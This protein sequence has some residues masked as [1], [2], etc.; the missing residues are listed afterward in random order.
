MRLIHK[1]KEPR[2]L[3]EYG[4]TEQAT[5]EGLPTATKVDLRAA[6]IRDQG[7][8][9][10]YCM[11]RIHHDEAREAKGLDQQSEG[12]VRIEHWKPQSEYPDLQLAWTN[13]FA[14][15]HGN[16]GK[17]PKD[18]HC[19]VRKGKQEMTVSPL[20]PKHIASLTYGTAGQIQS[21]DQ[22]LQKDLDDV[23]NLNHVTLQRNRKEAILGMLESLLQAERKRTGKPAGTLPVPVL[24]AKL[25]RCNEFDAQGRLP[26]FAGALAYKLEK[27]LGI[28]RTA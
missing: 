9:C 5:Y 7:G 24:R 4:K 14:A 19:D 1:G 13:L 3:V 27:R 6:L 15:C 11:G 10:C 28:S 17:D 18:Q 25:S 2:A 26:P 20:L 12:Q 21:N 16:E 23:L 8:L 22:T